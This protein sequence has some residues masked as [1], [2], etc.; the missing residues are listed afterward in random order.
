MKSI[1]LLIA[2]LMSTNCVWA[3]KTATDVEKTAISFEIK[4]AQLTQDEID[5]KESDFRAAGWKLGEADKVAKLSEISELKKKRNVS[6][7][8]AIHLTLRAYDLLPIQD[9]ILSYPEGKVVISGPWKGKD[10]YWIP[11][12]GDNDGRWSMDVKGRP[13]RLPPQVDPSGL[14]VPQAYT[15][16]DGVTTVLPIDFKTPGLLALSL[17]HEQ[18]HFHQY[19]TAG[20]GDK[21]TQAEREVEAYEAESTAMDQ[22]GLTPA[23]RTYEQDYLYGEKGELKKWRGIRDEE[24][25]TGIVRAQPWGNNQMSQL[26]PHSGSDT[27]TRMVVL[28]Q[29]FINVE[30][31]FVHERD[32]ARWQAEKQAKEEAEAAA[33]ERDEAAR[34]AKERSI[35]A[36]SAAA[37]ECGFRETWDYPAVYGYGE[38]KFVGYSL[39]DGTYE[40]RAYQFAAKT[41]DEF[42]VSLMLARTCDEVNGWKNDRRPAQVASPCN[43]GIAIFN[44]HANDPQFLDHI[45]AALNMRSSSEH[46]DVSYYACVEEKARQLR[47]PADEQQ[48]RRL[49][50]PEIKRNKKGN[51]ARE[52]WEEEQAEI[53]RRKRENDSSPPPRRDRGD[54]KPP[55]SDPCTYY[56]GIRMC[57]Q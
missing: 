50:D 16:P 49:F 5:R 13:I 20:A 2:A 38:Q 40:Y 15:F 39:H 12:A 34:L 25:R 23:E 48:Y 30:A 24:R 27:E 33:R 42:K 56:G 18:T 9:G 14:A 37:K 41:M 35:A 21:T 36:T 52:N 47:I 8:R 6:R 44:A 22:I 17:L 29:D 53:D 54:R 32:L 1:G 19:T 26:E 57:P 31:A 51:A 10:A 45:G 43:D 55:P 7:D 28:R 46:T 3:L 11:V 4:S